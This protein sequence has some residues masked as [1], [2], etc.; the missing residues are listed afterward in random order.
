MLNWAKVPDERGRKHRHRK[1]DPAA[2]EAA[3]EAHLQA[4]RVESSPQLG[5]LSGPLP[6]R[7]LRTA[8]LSSGG[9]SPPPIFF[10]QNH[11]DS[12]KPH[13]HSRAL[14]QILAAEMLHN[15]LF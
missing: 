3:R 9:A 8:V 13:L 15:E 2:G 11:R 7:A 5:R 14:Q 1:R 10:V 6:V 4:L 12:Q